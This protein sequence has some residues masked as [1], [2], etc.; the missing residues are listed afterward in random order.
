MRDDTIAAIATPPGSGAI[1]IIR[2]SGNNAFEIVEKI[3]KP[4]QKN[5]K[6]HQQKG[7]TIHFGEII[8]HNGQPVDNVLVSVFKA[9]HSYTGENSIE[10]S[11]HGSVYIQQKILELLLDAGARL[12]DP[13]E[14]TMRAFLNGKMDLS[15]AEAVA[16]LIASTSEAARLLAY[17]QLK[18]QVS[19]QLKILRQKLIDFVSLIELELDFPEEDVQFADR[20]QLLSLVNDIQN[21]IKSLLDTFQLGN[22]VKNGIPVAIVGEP[23]VGKSTLLNLLLKE[24]KAIVSEIPGTTRDTIED[25]ISLNGILFRFIDTAGLRKTN[26]KIEA[27]GIEKAKNTIKKAAIILLLINATDSNWKD[28]LNYVK[29]LVNHNQK[30]I[31][32]VN[33]IDTTSKP[34]KISA[35]NIPI[36]YIS[37]KFHKNIH[38]LEQILLQTINYQPLLQGNTIITNARHYQ[39]LQKAYQAL[40]NVKNSI[41]QGLPQDL[42]SFDIREA[43]YYIGEITGEITND[44]ILH[45]IFKNFCIGK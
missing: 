18:G 31:I 23:N 15:Q 26:D 14:F 7:Y 12:A 45:N 43:L 33:K 25:V 8:D 36:I 28:K 6:L 30:I 22:A 9:P 34:V 13:G 44:E 1:A 10:I 4:A 2:V 27:L 40:D 29:S 39:A 37:A 38:Q 16:D 41:N 17:R 21:N 19:N 24:D 32:L 20:T 42:L 35:E 3:F 11:C 5:K